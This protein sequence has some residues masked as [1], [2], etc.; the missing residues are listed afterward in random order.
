MS[1]YL[2][3]I[4]LCG[5]S[6]ELDIVGVAMVAWVTFVYDDELLAQSHRY[7]C[8]H[9]KNIAQMYYTS[10]EPRCNESVLGRTDAS[11]LQNHRLK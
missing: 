1:H 3:W 5:F 8:L 7:L 11:S 10:C 9:K 6:S 4:F 2:L